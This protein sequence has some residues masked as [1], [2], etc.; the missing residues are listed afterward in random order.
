MDGV[1]KERYRRQVTIPEIGAAGQ[2]RLGTTRI[3]L[4]GAGGLGCSV[5]LFLAAAGIGHLRIV[6]HGEVEESNLNR[7][8]LYSD[9]DIGRSKT[10]VSAER[11]KLV[12]P[13]VQV[14]TF[15]LSLDARSAASLAADCDVIVDAL[16]TT[17]ARYDL[18]RAAL[19]RG[20]PL[21]HGAV[22]GF[23][24]QVMTVLPGETPCLW[25]LYGGVELTEAPPVIGVAPGVIGALQA[26]EAIKLALGIGRGLRG[27]LL[28]YDGLSMRFSELEIPRDPDCPHCG[29]RA[30]SEPR[31]V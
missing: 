21:V 9:G 26:T 3:L 1:E 7:Q 12:N 29:G 17:T 20:I 31:G 25:C 27:R 23:A 28:I 22:S 8:I 10:E 4:A 5:A 16:D 11:L 19:D 13:L 14:E 6:D 2:E 18:N 30:R 15:R 24:G